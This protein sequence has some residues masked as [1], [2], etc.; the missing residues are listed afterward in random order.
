M[1]QTV[2]TNSAL[3]DAVSSAKSANKRVIFVPTMGNLHEGHYSLIEE[4]K[5]HGDFIVASIFVNPMQFG[6]NEDLDAYPRTLE[7]D[8]IGL[9]QHGCHLLFAPTA[10]EIY[11]N[12]TQAETSILVPEL[13]DLHCGASRPGHFIGVATVVCKLFN[14]VQPD[15][16]IFG[17]KDFQQLAVIRKMTRDLCLPIEIIGVPTSRESSGLARSSRNGYLSEIEK[18]KATQIHRTLE[19]CR[20]ALLNGCDSLAALKQE[21]ENQLVSKEFKIDYLNFACPDTLSIAQDGDRKIVILLA[22]WIGSTRLIDNIV[23]ALD[24]AP[25]K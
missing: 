7:A 5:L 19:F 12:G 22:A 20:Q 4:A 8:S 10:S 3:R 6:E 9:A 14:M 24:D 21:A 11:P 17:Q 15:S 25:I 18:S 16:A 23:V 1:L 13:C 2:H